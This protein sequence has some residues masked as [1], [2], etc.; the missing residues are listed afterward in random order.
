ML[1]VTA[2][3]LLMD[4]ELDDEAGLVRCVECLAQGLNQSLVVGYRTLLIIRLL[5]LVSQ[6]EPVRIRKVT[7]VII[8]LVVTRVISKFLQIFD[9]N[10]FDFLGSL[11]KVLERV[12]QSVSFVFCVAETEHGLK[13]HLCRLI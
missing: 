11:E 1:S 12:W 7:V 13:H 4:E 8:L 10:L 3:W 2:A 5:S 6:E 9:V